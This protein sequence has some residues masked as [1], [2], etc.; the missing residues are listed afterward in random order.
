MSDRELRLGEELISPLHALYDGLQVDGAPRR[1]HTAEHHPVWV[2]TRYQDAKTVLSHPSVRRD[3]RQAAELYARRTGV[4]GTSVGACLTAHMLNADPPDHGR[5]RALVR[6]AFTSRQIENL[7]PYIERF[8]EGLL[9]AMAAKELA[10]LMADFAV[11]LTIAVI[12]ELLGVPESEREHVRGSWEQQAALLSPKAAEALATQQADYLR[13]LLEAKRKH[14]SDDVFSNLVRADEAG[15][16][17]EV[18]LVSMAHLLLMSGFETTMNMIGNAMV[19]LLTHPDQLAQ[20]RAKPDL[21]PNALEELVRHDSPVRAS[22]LRFTVADVELGDVTIPAGEYVLVSNLT[23]NH[24]PERFANPDV[25]D[26]NRNTDGHL[27]YGFGVHYCVGAQLA[28]LEARIAIARLLHRFPELALA[29][30]H[31]ELMWLPITFLRAL[32]SVPITPG[33]SAA[34]SQDKTRTHQ[35]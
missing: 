26:L 31:S 28:R 4:S 5:M 19:T 11:P 35:S 17:T 1:A 13:T 2:V 21:L 23:A 6:T 27:G 22:M 25:L 16:L 15:Q 10:D 8:T 33:P 12:C 7:Q 18:E 30:P 29:V 14:P 32:I 3:A 24:D 34:P 20:L 9:D